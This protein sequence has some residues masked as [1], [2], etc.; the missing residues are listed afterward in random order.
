M[1]KPIVRHPLEPHLDSKPAPVGLQAACANDSYRLFAPHWSSD[2]KDGAVVLLEQGPYFEKALTQIRAAGDW[3]LTVNSGQRAVAAHD[4]DFW[5][6]MDFLIYQVQIRRILFAA[7]LPRLPRIVRI[8]PFGMIGGLAS[9]IADLRD[10]IRVGSLVTSRK[11]A[12][13]EEL[14]RSLSPE[15]FQEVTLTLKLL[16]I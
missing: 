5:I 11:I 6:A 4:R 2:T 8:S 1:H 3:V 13:G 16:R 15:V 10:I 14:R 9:R 7:V 12:L